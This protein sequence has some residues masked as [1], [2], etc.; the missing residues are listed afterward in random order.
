MLYLSQKDVQNL[1]NDDMDFVEKIIQKTFLN[2]KNKTFSLGGI[3]KASHGMQMS[4]DLLGKKHLFIAMPGYLGEPFNVSG[5]KWHGPMLKNENQK[6][7]SNYT[8]ILNE[9]DTGLAFAIMG[10]NAITD[11]RTAAISLLA[12]KTLASKNSQ[13]LSI[14]G[15]GK[16]NLLLT[17]A[18]IK[19]F[20]IKQILIKGRGLASALKFKSCVESLNKNIEIK[21]LNNVNEACQNA[22]IISINTGF[23]FKTLAD[24]PLIKEKYIKPNATFLCS[25]FAYFSDLMIENA[26]KITD[27]YPMY[28]EY[29]KE[30]GAPVYKKLSYI[31]NRFVDLI[32]LGKIQA[33][34]VYNIFDIKNENFSDKIKIFSNGGIALFDLALGYEIYRLSKEKNLGIDLKNE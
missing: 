29:E 8:L 21:I 11:Y 24:M 32:R 27:Y 10:A 23:D 16:I 12:A 28:E 18:L 13:I 22:D 1:I 20:D 6:R 34:S 26:Y 4:Y 19:H 5:L 15:P 2:F 14:I 17:K 7:D 31:G 3:N 25:A 33:N 9:P 30:L